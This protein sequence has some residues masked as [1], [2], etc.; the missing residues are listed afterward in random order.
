ML[1]SSLAVDDNI[2]EEQ[3]NT[4]RPE[5]V[6]GQPP[7]HPEYPLPDSLDAIELVMAFEEEFG[8]EV[9]DDDIE[10]IVTVADAT[11][12]VDKHLT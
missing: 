10:K 2:P 6:E 12:Y 7:W 5:P 1:F 8:I 11:A 4:V 3:H 9:D